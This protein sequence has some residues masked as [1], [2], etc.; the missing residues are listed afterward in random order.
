MTLESEYYLTKTRFLSTKKSGPNGILFS[1]AFDKN[2]EYVQQLS[3]GSRCRRDLSV[4]EL[5]GDELVLRFAL[6]DR[7]QGVVGSIRW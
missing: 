1:T 6:N 5:L 7:V 3:R 4:P 2:P